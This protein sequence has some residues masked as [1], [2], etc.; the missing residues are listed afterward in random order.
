MELSPLQVKQLTKRYRREGGA[1]LEAVSDLS[2]EVRAGECFGLLGPNGAGKSTAIHCISGFYPPSSGKVFIGGLDVHAEPKRAR[3]I[4]G[5]CAQE[6]TLD[7]DFRVY[8]QLVRYATFFRVPAAEAKRRAS[9]LLERFGIADKAGELVESLSG[10]MKRRLQVAR[11]LISAPSVLVLDEATTGLDPGM[12]R[13]LWEIVREERDKGAAI[14][15]C[16]HY[17]EEAERLCDRVALMDRGRIRALDSPRR[18]VERHMGSAA[19]EEELRPGVLWKRAPHLEDVYLKLTG[20]RLH[21]PE[22]PA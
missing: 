9:A 6:D 22:G 16:T 15:L 17:M 10:G 5:V 7:S 21:E 13:S 12:R 20:A 4:L 18:L 2:F 14:L 1:P 11:A 8:D 19:V 3:Q